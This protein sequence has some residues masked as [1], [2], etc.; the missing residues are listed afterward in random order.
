MSFTDAVNGR[1]R[2]PAGTLAELAQVNVTREPGRGGQDVFRG[3]CRQAGGQF[4]KAASAT[5]WR[6]SHAAPPAACTAMP[7]AIVMT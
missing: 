2:D 1:K 6:S 7:F 3:P 5:C 4:R